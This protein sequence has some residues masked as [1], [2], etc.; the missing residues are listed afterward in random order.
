MSGMLVFAAFLFL[1]C[2]ALI[3]AEVFVPSGGLI[4]AC[5]VLCLVGGLIIFFKQ[6]A[7]AGWAG[8]GVAVIM[9]P[10]VLVFSFKMLPKTKFGKSVMLTPSERKV[11]DAIPDTD[12]LKALLGQTGTVISPLRPVGMCDFDGNR[13]ECVAESGYVENDNSVTVIHVEGTQLTVRVNN[14]N[15]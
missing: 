13:I 10:S 11:G 1:A 12:K 8:M 6:S 9:I 5:A 2:A 14:E 4:S 15:T 3:V 7:V